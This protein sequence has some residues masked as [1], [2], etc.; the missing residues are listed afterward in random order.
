MDA[1]GLASGEVGRAGAA[2]SLSDNLTKV[3]LRMRAEQ[4]WKVFSE[5]ARIGIIGFGGGNALVP[6][7]EREVVDGSSTVGKEELDREVVVANITPG[8]LPVEV[9]SGVGRKA[10]GAGGMIAGALGMGLPGAALT[11][12]LIAAF[13][14]ASGAVVRQV[15][16]ASV[17]VAMLI[18][19]VLCLYAVG[20]VRQKA[21]HS[22]ERLVSV[23]LLVGVFVLT[24]GKSIAKLV[25]FNPIPFGLSTLEVLGI[26]FFV[27]FYAGG[28]RIRHGG[29][30]HC[31]SI[32]AGAGV[33]AAD[34]GN[35]ANEG[36]GADAGRASFGGV[37]SAF[38]VAGNGSN[39]SK[40]RAT[41]DLRW[42][43][44]AVAAVISVLYLLAANGVGLFGLSQVK[45]ALQLVMLGL[46]AY[47]FV[48]GLLGDHVSL[49]RFPWRR[50]A[51]ESLAWVAFV[52]L[53]CLPAL[54]AVP[55]AAN[56]L[57][58]SML[59]VLMSFGGG[60]AYLAFGHGMFVDG[61][62]VSSAQYYEQ[63]VTISNAMPGSIICKVLTGVG[64]LVGSAQSTAGG[65]W[66]ALAGFAVGVGVSGLS[67]LVMYYVYEQFEHLCVFCLVK[68]YIRPI[69]GGLLLGIALSMVS[70]NVGVAT[71]FGLGVAPVMV[72]SA[73][74]LVLVCWLGAAREWP[75]SRLILLAVVVALAGCNLLAL[76]A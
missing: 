74:V 63:V 39:G 15:R 56:M 18:V 35:G 29:V 64:Y 51:T 10:A 43:R 20:A 76:L 28:G 52:V 13:S 65:F 48:G 26:A 59:S 23:G 25:G 3:G 7:I 19:Y 40:A 17:G 42:M 6:V 16:F 53:L 49:R 2:G 70:L 47:G 4:L 27:I 46:G 14:S 21:A 73:A 41:F 1:S 12:L 61:G 62:L 50:F 69:I 71:S 24:G 31:Q 5:M 58:R 30:S 38:A 32:G 72:L 45:V 57:G 55:E 44:G 37:V 36:I 54:V 22:R 68:R 34:L 66:L 75:L 33:A 8:A 11:L 67:F 60:D 9:A